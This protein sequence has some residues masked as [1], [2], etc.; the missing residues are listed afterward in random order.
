MSIWLSL[1][2]CLLGGVIYFVTDNPA[3]PP[4]TT[5]NQKFNVIGL[6]MFWVGLLAFLLQYIKA[7]SVL[8]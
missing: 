5:I 8:K 7:L 3:T 6:H 2:V 4:P 1:A